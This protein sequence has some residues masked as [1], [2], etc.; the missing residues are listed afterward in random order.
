MKFSTY[1]QCHTVTYVQNIHI[2]LEIY[3]E[4]KK[5]DAAKKLKIKYQSD[6]AVGTVVEKTIFVMIITR[7]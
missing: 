1:T 7:K 4:K 6:S 3:H 2:K 5:Q